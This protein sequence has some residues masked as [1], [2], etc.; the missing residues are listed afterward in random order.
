MTLGSGN[1]KKT[2]DRT[3]AQFVIDGSVRSDG[4]CIKMT[5]LLTDTR[6]G[7][8]IWSESCR[9]SIEAAKLIA[10]QEEVARGMAVKIA[11]EQGWIAKSL[12]K[13]SKRHAPQH[14]SVY[15]AVL[16]YYKYALTMTPASFSGALAALEKAVIIDPECGQAWSMS[17]RLFADIYAFDI[18]GF[19]DPLDKAFSF[20]QKGMRLSPDDQRCRFIMAYVH[21]LGND[22]KAGL[23]EA[24]RALLL[25]PQTLFMLDGIGY[26]MTLL[27]AWERGPALIEKIIQLNPFYGNYVHHALWL[28]CL[29]QK[30]YTEAY[31]ETLKLNRPALFWDHLARTSTYGLLGNI[32]DGRKAAAELLKLK[33]DFAARGR[34]LMG[35]F[36]KFEDIVER[37]IEGLDAVGIEVR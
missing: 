14:S 32:E 18:A 30:N 9:S 34:I 4:T 28:N 35:H 24:E 20:G 8:L 16:R 13:A 27:G 23:A 26:L 12:D 29:R 2:A 22:L 1:R 3:A 7:R 5:V 10:F 15:Q 17:A 33:P 6:T 36:I 21:L 31:H 11:G 37:V 25:G 19:K